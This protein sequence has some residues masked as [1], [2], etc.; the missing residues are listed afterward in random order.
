MPG[1]AVKVVTSADGNMLGLIGSVEDE[2]PDVK[3][4]DG[5]TAQQAEAIT[6]Q[7]MKDTCQAG[8]ELVDLDTLLTEA[9]VVNFAGLSGDLCGW[10]IQSSELWMA[11]GLC[12]FEYLEKAI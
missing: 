6:L 5:I 11:L 2:L 4:A 12:L 7:S 10:F 9:D 3:E 1:G 8:A